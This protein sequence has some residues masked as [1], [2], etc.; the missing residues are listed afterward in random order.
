VDEAVSGKSRVSTG[1]ILTAVV[2]V[3]RYVRQQNQETD[4]IAGDL[5]EMAV[6]V[7]LGL[8]RMEIAA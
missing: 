5:A 7:N 8:C 3:L 6:R 4:G 1:R 2:V